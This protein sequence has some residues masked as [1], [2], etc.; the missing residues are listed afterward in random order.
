[1]EPKSGGA[2]EERLIHGTGVVI[3]TTRDLQISDH[4]ARAN[5]SGLVNNHRQRVKTL[6]CEH[7]RLGIIGNAMLLAQRVE[8]A[9]QFS[10]VSCGQFSQL[11]ARTCLILVG[12]TAFDQQLGHFVGTDLVELIDLTEH[13]LDIGQAKTTVE[14]FRK[15]TVVRMHG[16]LRQTELTQTFQ[17]RY[18]DQRQLDLVM[19]GQIT[20]ADHI[21]IGL[22]ELAETTFL[23]AFATPDLLNLPTLER[24]C[25]IAG[26]FDHI[27]AQR[28]SQIE[29]QTKAVLNRSVGL[30]T[31]LLK[32]AQQVNFL[33][34]FALLEQT[35]TLLNSTSFNANEA[36]E[37]EKL[38]GACR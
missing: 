27:T 14:T 37:L 3:Q 30:M 23:R 20:V 6:T 24:E 17:C 36:I 28:N 11:K 16:G 38:H 19:I 21:D 26:M 10:A 22:H 9:G 1:M 32:A 18:H 8:L 15:L 13:A 7:V 5:T 12:S 33:A 25:Q 2:V 31:D 29:V 34:G 4:G 35:R